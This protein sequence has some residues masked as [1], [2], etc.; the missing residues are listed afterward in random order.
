MNP[1]SR[2]TSAA[3]R[4]LIRTPQRFVSAEVPKDVQ[5]GVPETAEPEPLELDETGEQ[6]TQRLKL[7]YHPSTFTAQK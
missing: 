2:L 4:N 6:G 5:G 1:L 7:P 3:F